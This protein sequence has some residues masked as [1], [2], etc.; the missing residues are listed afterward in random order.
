M[1]NEF[2]NWLEYVG[3]T[4]LIFGVL[5]L[6]IFGSTFFVLWQLP[7]AMYLRAL[8]AAWV[9]GSVVLATTAWSKT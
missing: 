6:L 1:N 5:M 8:L 2:N 9:C 3:A 7:P 4:A